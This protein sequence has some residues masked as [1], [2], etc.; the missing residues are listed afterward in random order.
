MN[1]ARRHPHTFSKINENTFPFLTGVTVLFVLLVL[2][3]SLSKM[4]LIYI[5]MLNDIRRVIKDKSYGMN[6]MK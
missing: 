1:N 4:S 6:V 5:N 2:I 3:L